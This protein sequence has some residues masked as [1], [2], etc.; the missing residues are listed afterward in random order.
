MSDFNKISVNSTLSVTQAN[1]ATL[2]FS[3]GK[4]LANDKYSI[5]NS[6]VNLID[7]SLNTLSVYFNV[8]KKI[9]E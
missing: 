5:A 2:C 4:I 1:Q 6:Q 8:T 7:T 3:D 9:I